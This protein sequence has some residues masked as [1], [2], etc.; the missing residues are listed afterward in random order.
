MLYGIDGQFGSGKTSMSVYMTKQIALQM[1]KDL[2]K[3]LSWWWTIIISNIKMDKEKIPNYFYFEDDKLLEV[4]RSINAINDIERILYWK[5]TKWWIMKFDRKKFTKFKVFFDESWAI[6]NNHKKIDNNDIYT[7]YANQNR[8]NFMDL[9]L[10]SARGAENFKTLR[11]KVDWWYFVKPLSKLP[12]LND[13]WLIYRE[14]RED[15]WQTLVMEKFLAKDENGDYI[16]KERPIREF[17][18]WFWKPWVR[19]LYDD[20]HKNIR[21]PEKYT[22]LNKD[23]IKNIIEFKANL[24]WPLLEHDNFKILRQ[25]LNLLPNNKENVNPFVSTSLSNKNS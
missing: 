23:L 1:T 14:Q 17:V 10:V 12:F 22:N 7:E 3:Y 18:D 19:G 24:K 9:Y 13:I 25:Q 11:S 21:D 4:L 6:M 5:M 20:L 8:K 16:A 15:D 2:A